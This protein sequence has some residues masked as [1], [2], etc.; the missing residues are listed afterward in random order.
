MLSKEVKKEKIRLRKE[1]D[2]YLDY[3]KEVTGRGEWAENTTAYFD[4][5]IEII[6]ERLKEIGR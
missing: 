1:L 6:V 4:A 3:Y 5:Q 2:F